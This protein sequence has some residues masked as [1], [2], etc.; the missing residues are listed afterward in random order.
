MPRREKRKT[1]EGRAQEGFRLE[2]ALET[3]SEDE[4]EVYMDKQDQDRQRKASTEADR[5]REWPARGRGWTG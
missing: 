4:E 1:T 2:G 3:P 5:H